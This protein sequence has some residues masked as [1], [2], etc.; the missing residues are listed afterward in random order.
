[1]CSSSGSSIAASV[2]A[3]A[4]GSS[5]VSFLVGTAGRRDALG[6]ELRHAASAALDRLGGDKGL[7]AKLASA[8]GLILAYRGQYPDARRPATGQARETA[9]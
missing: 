5:T 8:V 3:S 4:S 2:L 7:E 9:R 1:M 6:F